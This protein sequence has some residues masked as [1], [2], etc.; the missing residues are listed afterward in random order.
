[1]TALLKSVVSEVACVA[2]FEVRVSN[3]VDWLAAL[4]VSVSNRL[5]CVAAFDVKLV[6]AALA[7]VTF[8]LMLPIILDVGKYRPTLAL[9]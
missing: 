5:A 8:A 1:M 3:R 6:M 2:A 4:P 9:P 7:A